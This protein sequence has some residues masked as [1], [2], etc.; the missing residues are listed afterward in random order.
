ME[1]PWLCTAS[2]TPSVEGNGRF[3]THVNLNY[4]VNIAPLH[5]SIILTAHNAE[6][7]RWINAHV[8]FYLE[9]ACERLGHEGI[10]ALGGPQVSPRQAVEDEQKGLQHPAHA[11]DEKDREV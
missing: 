11:G 2:T 7:C 9:L 8:V 6:T 3:I 5:D 1:R 4:R 10:G